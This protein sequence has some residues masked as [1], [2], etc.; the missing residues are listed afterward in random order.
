M[1]VTDPPPIVRD[2]VRVEPPCEIVFVRVRYSL[3]QLEEFAER[4]FSLVDQTDQADF[5]AVSVDI[6][7]NQVT[8]ES[9]AEPFPV[10]VRHDIHEVVPADAVRFVSGVERQ[11][12]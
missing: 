5:Y 12:P 2:K 8:A 3:T 6:G 11:S 10:R 9:S 4:I 7:A 1:V